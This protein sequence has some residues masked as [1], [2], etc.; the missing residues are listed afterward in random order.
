MET[1]SLVLLLISLVIFTVIAWKYG[2]NIFDAI[3]LICLIFLLVMIFVTLFTIAK[4]A[5]TKPDGI[6]SANS[7]TL[8][9]ML[10]FIATIYIIFWG[11]FTLLNKYTNTNNILSP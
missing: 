7:D 10:I 1:F 4:D 5:Q 8:V 6:G 9:T 3:A 11:F 2:Y